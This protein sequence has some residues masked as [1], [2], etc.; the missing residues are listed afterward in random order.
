MS[1]TK[2]KIRSVFKGLLTA[3]LLG[4]QMILNGGVFIS[5]MMIPL[6]SYLFLLPN[7]LSMNTAALRTEI[8]LMF[9][10]GTFIVGRIVALIGGI[11]FCIAGL[12]WIWYRHKKMGLFRK[13]LYSQIRHPQ[14]T[15]IIIV[16]MG[17]TIM[18]LTNGNFD[19]GGPLVS[20]T[21]LNSLQVVGLWFLQVLGY[22]AIAR[23]EEW[24]LF[25]SYGKEYQ[26]YRRQTSF[27]FPI[28]SPKR[29]P[30]TFFTVLLVVILCVVLLLL[31]YDFIRVYSSAHFPTLT[32][33]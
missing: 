20:Q 2:A 1:K 16:T 7:Y 30:E 21:Y 27:L 24:H 32:L 33:P 28:K 3:L 15:G 12:Q 22:I 17:L 11:I 6:L 4:T 31:P 18:V 5:V 13:G 25:K 8:W 26:E 19:L 9:F 14:F 23:F 29:I 10:S